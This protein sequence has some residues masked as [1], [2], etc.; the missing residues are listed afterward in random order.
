MYNIYYLSRSILFHIYLAVI[1]LCSLKTLS[2]QQLTKEV[3]IDKL[4][5]SVL[6]CGV[7]AVEGLRDLQQTPAVNFP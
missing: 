2:Y 1:D 7:F 5:L 3:D 6:S 4:R